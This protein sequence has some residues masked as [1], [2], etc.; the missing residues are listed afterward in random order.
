VSLYFAPLLGL[1][2]HPY[3]RTWEKH[4]GGIKSGISRIYGPFLTF[5]HEAS[6]LIKKIQEPLGL[7]TPYVPQ[8]LSGKWEHC[9]APLA[10]WRKQYPL[11]NWNLGCPF[12]RIIRK[13]RGAG[14]LPKAPDLKLFLTHWRAAEPG[15]L[16]I[17]IRLG[18]D[19]DLSKELISLFKD[20][21]EIQEI[22][23]HPRLAMDYYQGPLR[24]ETFLEWKKSFGEKMVWSG[25]IWRAKD[26]EDLWSKIG[27]DTPLMLGRGL[28]GDPGLGQR[29]LGN[30]PEAG[31]YGRWLSELL[32]AYSPGRLKEYSKHWERS[33]FPDT[34]YWMGFRKITE[35]EQLLS[36]LQPFLNQF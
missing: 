32:P 14:L 6:S 10:I 29:I 34:Q 28:V 3:L 27:R 25:E 23:L 5:N 2:D 24:L 9:R 7:V 21:P 18:V 35:K 13:G 12:P 36:Y 8:F 17:K 11:A 20:F 4:F 22:I 31:A 16:S 26:A 15:G 30:P 1:V 33:L 19:R